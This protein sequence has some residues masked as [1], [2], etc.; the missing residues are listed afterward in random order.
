MKKLQEMKL[1]FAA[2]IQ[3]LLFDTLFLVSMGLSF[4]MFITFGNSPMSK[5]IMG[6]VAIVFESTKLYDLLKAKQALKQS[7]TAKLVFSS[8]SYLIKA[9]LSIIAS[10]GFALVLL[11][12]QSNLAEVSQ[13]TLILEANDYDSDILFWSTKLE[14]VSQELL[15]IAEKKKNNPD[16]WGVVYDRL[17]QDGVNLESNLMTYKSKLDEV[18]KA[19]LVYQTSL[20]NGQK[21]VAT[22]PADM[23]SEL[24]KFINS[25]SGKEVITTH[26]LMSI[27]FIL[28]MVV[29]EVS[30]AT[31]SGEL[32]EEEKQAVKEVNLVKPNPTLK[33]FYT[34]FIEGLYKEMRGTGLNSSRKVSEL[35]GL[36]LDTCRKLRKS[37]E[38]MTFKGKPLLVVE[39]RRTRSGLSRENLIKVV[40]WLLDNPNEGMFIPELP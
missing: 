32:P 33:E 31:T 23:F 37:I 8:I 9:L 11:S 14:A 21:E 16:G 17:V 6:L 36:E 5:G 12:A 1:L 2:G 24:S 28:I 4:M 35:T 15:I 26:N 27:I 40:T 19:K 18:K 7:N 39:D 38:T 34:T 20:Q 30:I 10:V 22:N 13:D 3:S 29:M 25:V